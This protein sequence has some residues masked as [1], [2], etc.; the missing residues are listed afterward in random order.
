MVVFHRISPEAMARNHERATPQRVASVPKITPP[1]NFGPVL[2]L[3]DTV[4][5][6]FRGHAYG[7]PPVPWHVGQRL[8]ALRYDAVAAMGEKGILT[9]SA[10]PGYFRA[11]QQIADV[12]WRHCRPVA[13]WQ[14]WAKRL[15]LAKNPFRDGTEADVVALAD[16]FAV[17]RM[18]ATVGFPASAEAPHPATH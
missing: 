5:L 3:G 7:V 13:R 14:R 10:V 2:D 18:S 15:G 17:R 9:P 16:F 11:V 6:T 1:K 12:C 8:I 4:Y